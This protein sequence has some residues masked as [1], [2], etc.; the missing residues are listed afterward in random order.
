MRIIIGLTALLLPVWLAGCDC[1]PLTSCEDDNEGQLEVV[2]LRQTTSSPNNLVMNVKVLD[3]EG[4]GIAGLTATHFTLFEDGT[5]ASQYE[6]K[7]QIADIPGEFAFHAG[8]LLDLSGSITA[9]ALDTL[10]LAATSFVRDLFAGG[11]TN[12]DLT[13]WWFD[14]NA[15]INQIGTTGRDTTAI[16][17]SIRALS[18]NLS[19]DNSTDLNGAVM[20]GIDA[21]QARVRADSARA[22]ASAGALVLFTDGTDQAGRT[23][24]ATAAARV[25]AARPAVATFTIGVGGEINR[26]SLTRI[27]RAGSAFAQS[28]Q[29]LIT[30]FRTVA[31]QVRR[32]AN[33]FYQVR[34]CSPKRVGTHELRIDVLSPGGRKGSVRTTFAA[35]DVPTVCR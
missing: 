5:R 24:E 26:S 31:E 20:R 8:L 14:G 33:S 35:T 3:P 19:T 1:A 32:D 34:Y 28:R 30:A 23:T 22:A 6:A 12:G 4:R 27:G 9:P 15:R 10:K 7:T 29:E 18:G 25:D 13:V 2:L 17:A 21:I 16:N 11:L